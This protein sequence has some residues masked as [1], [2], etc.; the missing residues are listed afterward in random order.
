MLNSNKNPVNLHFKALFWPLTSLVVAWAVWILAGL[1]SYQWGIYPKTLLGLTGI[2]SS[3]FIHSYT[4][5]AHIINNSIAFLFMGWMLFYFYRPVA[6]KVWLIVWLAG[7]FWTWLIGRPSFHVGMSGWVYGLGF[8]LVTAAFLRGNKQLIAGALIIIM[9]YGSMVWG[10]FPVKHVPLSWEGHLAGA[11]AGIM[12]AFYYRKVFPS[13]VEPPRE[14]P[15]EDE[16]EEPWWEEPHEGTS[17]RI[18]YTYKPRQP[19]NQ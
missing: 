4:D 2:I 8:Y 16:Q 11:L 14:W 15:P 17:T 6:W 7:G 3:P 5:P 9:E 10:I 12:A 18:N 19:D 13:Q 1:Q